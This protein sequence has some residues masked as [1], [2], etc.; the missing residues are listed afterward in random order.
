MNIKTILE[1]TVR[2]IRAIPARLSGDDSPLT[3]PWEEIK[4]QV[5]HE[6]CFFWQTYLDTMKGIIEGM[7]DSLS[8]QVRELIALTGVA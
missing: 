5:Q 1:D 3:D 6:R 2:T 7:V 8:E 4:E